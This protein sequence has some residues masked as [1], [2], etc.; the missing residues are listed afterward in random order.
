MCRSSGRRTRTSISRS[1]ST[2]GT[3]RRLI[4]RGPRAPRQ[5]EEA[6]G[7]PEIVDRREFVEALRGQL[8]IDPRR[9]A[10]LAVDV[11]RGHLDPE[12]GTMPVAPDDAA[13]VRAAVAR[14]LG[15]AR[16]AHVPVIYILLTYRRT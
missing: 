1:P 12:I 10:I 5:R 4:H 11:H 16:A 9:T 2:P 13:R 14:L 15:G 6:W 3:S 8:A 7:M